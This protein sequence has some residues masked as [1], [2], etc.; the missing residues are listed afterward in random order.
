MKIIS[1]IEF[2]SMGG[3]GNGIRFE[4]DVD[5]IFFDATLHIDVFEGSAL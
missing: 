5:N 2:E 4:V 3:V 1:S